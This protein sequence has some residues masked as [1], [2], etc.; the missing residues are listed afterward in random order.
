MGDR[1]YF[2]VWVRVADAE[3]EAGKALIERYFGTAPPEALDGPLVEYVDDQMNWGGQDFLGDWNNEGFMCSG[4]QCG[5]SDYGPSSF[6]TTGKET[7]VLDYNTGKDGGFTI[8]FDDDGVPNEGDV[9]MVRDFIL[10]RKEVWAEMAKGPLELLADCAEPNTT[11][12][13]MRNELESTQ[14]R[15]EAARSGSHD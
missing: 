8:D 4:N 14:Q 3:T 13:G 5:G 11:Q 12:R 6:C 15:A 7:G 1:C 9:A 10:S 2:S